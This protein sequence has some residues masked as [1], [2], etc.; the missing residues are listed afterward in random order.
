MKENEKF[1][2]AVYDVPTDAASPGGSS[3]RD[4]AIR[5]IAR[6]IAGREEELARQIVA[7]CREEIVDYGA[8]DNS[9]SAD[10]ARLAL[11]NLEAL[12]A[13]L[14]R[15]EPISS[16]QLEKIRMGAA[17]RVHQGVSL[18][19]FL[20]AGR[21]WGQLTWETLRAAARID[22]PHEPEAAL[23]IASRVMRHVDIVS[24]AG[25]HAYL[26]EAQGLSNYGPV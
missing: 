2:T 16:R 21:L 14:E 8:A 20:H 12:L 17:Q 25:A 26:N 5:A 4:E 7:R 22:G 24:T 10:V 11:D 13:N 3:A 6:R 15:G 19:S 9:V 1:G 18:E 23:E